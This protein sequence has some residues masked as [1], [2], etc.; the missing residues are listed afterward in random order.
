MENNGIKSIENYGILETIHQSAEGVIY[1]AI[2]KT[3]G[4]KVLIKK[5][6]PELNWS[7]EVLNDFFNLAGY[8]RFIEHEYILTVLDFGKHEGK[9]YIVFA[10]HL[11]T[12]LCDRVPVQTDQEKIANF[13]YKAA[14]ALDFIHRQE[15]LHGG[16]SPENIAID[17]HGY[18]L[19]F[20]FGLS[21]V[22][23]KLLRENMDDGFYNLST[24]DL[25]CT[26]PE[27]ILEHSPTR[28]SDIY[29]FG[30]ISFY[31]AFGKFPFEGKYTHELALSHFNR[32]LI[33]IQPS[34]GVSVSILKFIQKCIQID[35]E[36]RFASFSQILEALERIKS[37]KRIRVRFDKRFAIKTTAGDARIPTRVSRPLAGILVLG[38][39]FGLVYYLSTHR[40]SSPP[41]A[42]SPATTLPAAA[43]PTS[44]QRVEVGT[45]TKHVTAAPTLPT[46]VET[47]Y[48]LAI[49]G[50]KPYMPDEVI[51][52]ANI[53]N[54]SEISRLGYGKPEEADVAPDNIHSAI[55]TSAGVYIFEGNQPLEW[56]DPQ[57]W[58]TSVQFSPDS[59]TLA[60]GL[61]TG[62]IQLWDWENKTKS[63][64]LSGEW[65]HTG[66]INR[67]LFVQNAY[68]YSASADRHV[69][70]WDWQ[71][72]KSVRDIPA[73]SQP[74]NDIAV[75]SDGKILITCADDQLIRVWDLASSSKLYE[76]D[77]D[78]FD[79]AIKALA[80]SSDDAYL[81]AGGE[82]GRLY[83]WKF[84]PA[85]L[86][87]GTGLQL[88]A[89]IVPVAKRIWSLEYIR[90]DQE[91]LLGVDDGESITYDATRTDYGG[92]SHVFDLPVRSKDLYDAFGSSFEFASFSVFDGSNTISINWD[93]EI[94]F[95]NSQIVSPAFDNLDRLDF[96][97]DGSI[98]AAGG[99]Y[100][101]THVWDL[102]T[103]ETLYQN[104]YF[105]PF[106]D[107]VA[108]DGSSIA[109]IVPS[110][111]PRVGDIYQLKRLTGAQTTLDL[112]NV[113]PN[114]KVGY[115]QNGGVF[116]VTDT[117]T[118]KAWD[119]N[120]GNEI[121][122]RA[123]DHFGCRITTPQNNAK[124]W[125]LVN[126]AI[127]VFLPGDEAHIDSLC[128]KAFQIRD[129][130]A[131]FSRDL[132]LLVFINSNGMLEGYDVLSKS[133]P[134]QPYRFAEADPVTS[135][136]V[137]PNAAIIAVGTASGRIIFFD[138]KTG[139]PVSEIVANFG[140]LQAIE[141]S[142][143]GRLIATAGTDGVVRVFGIGAN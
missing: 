65:H 119:F 47:G 19:L 39:S 36:K 30:I 126:S 100:G 2:E 69:I 94:R 81:A 98:L 127:D 130:V 135:M 12:L 48:Q 60:I 1:R 8:L 42:A 123:Q 11:A 138:G 121:D 64:S 109:I 62:E 108:P 35:P 3:S 14:E 45:P 143:D 120:A 133:A 134:W 122:V 37:G 28:A 128:P 10:D 139:Q 50:E 18:P 118:A 90:D 89:D 115:T 91:L 52:I 103:N 74:V 82:A 99:K 142:E 66:K 57:G 92:A 49:E 86:P 71:S 68:L 101:S 75:T 13:L 129:N 26:T 23:R 85:P 9:P 32:S 137:S 40:F 7:D 96:S 114:G 84:V 27:Q 15:V 25:K 80:I 4:N 93:G 116:I 29:A 97:P 78:Y 55:A 61:M 88:R 20:D 17:P 124:D 67:L 58:A 95:Q 111:D 6:Y 102:T 46:P 110:N 77:S 73:H 105:M 43:E 53:A 117:M 132:N 79:G 107:P 56:I 83:Q 5:Y 59:R 31:Y 63:V 76:L 112:S 104:F 22:F 70:V 113:L 72:G 54:L 106:G 51:S 41:P 38:L 131:A 24:A 16:L 34:K 140:R 141:F 136:A 33:P 87:A 44:T 21:E 125:L